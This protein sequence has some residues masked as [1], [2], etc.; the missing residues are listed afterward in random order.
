MW[1]SFRDMS[2]SSKPGLKVGYKEIL[3]ELPEEE[4]KGY[5]QKRFDCNPDK[6]TCSCCG[7]DF[8]VIESETLAKATMVVRKCHIDDKTGEWQD[9]APKPGTIAHKYNLHKWYQTLDEYIERDDVLV[10]RREEIDALY[11]ALQKQEESNG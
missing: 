2:T 11:H 6:H 4:A 7:S 9:S 8:S 10:I 3:I 5:F 1:T